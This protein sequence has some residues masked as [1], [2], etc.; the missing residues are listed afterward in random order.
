MKQKSN[1]EIYRELCGIEAS[2]PIYSKDWYL[3]AVCGENNWNVSLVVKGNEVFASLPY[4]IEKKL[5]LTILQMPQLTQVLGPWIKY[6]PDQKYETKLKHEE[7]MISELISSLPKFDYF[8]QKVHY[9]YVNWLPFYWQGFSQTTNYTYVISDTTDIEKVFNEFNGSTKRQIKK[10]EK[11]LR[12][13]ESD[14]IVKFY[15]INR[16]T[17][18]R[19][20]KKIPYSLE[21]LKKLDDTLKEHDSRKILFAQKG[22]DIHAVVYFIYDSSSV[23]YLMGGIDP[24]FSSSGAQS[25][26]MWEGIKLASQRN[27]VFDFEGS[28][29][30]PIERFFRS[31]GA[32]Q[33]NISRISKINSGF[34]KLAFTLKGQ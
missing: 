18:E 31:F 26:L 30:K 7:K 25:L 9:N 14:D 13:A 4:Y 21:F 1:K 12:V 32:R 2:I 5:G 33:K 23:Y 34:I 27:S 29:I 6:P 16:M 20:G 10:A 17:F 3:D 8:K 24:K 11:V 28:M 15:E 19:N 22:D